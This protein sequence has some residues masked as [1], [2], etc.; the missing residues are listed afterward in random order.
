MKAI[1]LSLALTIGLGAFAQEGDH[2]QKT[3]AEKA[4]RRTEQMVKDLGLDAAQQ[5]KVAAINLT[6]ANSIK[7]VNTMPDNAAREKRG[8]VVKANRDNSL[9]G[10]LTPEQYSKMLSLRAEKKAAHKADK[11]DKKDKS[12]D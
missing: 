4:E 12:E 7:N 3:A 2:T 11:K 8:D 6:Y 1:F 10:V 9:K 5:E